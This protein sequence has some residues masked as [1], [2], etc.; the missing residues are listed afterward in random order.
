MVI[1]GGF[2]SYGRGHYKLQAGG[3]KAGKFDGQ[4]IN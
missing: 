3:G 4:L 2:A 1:V